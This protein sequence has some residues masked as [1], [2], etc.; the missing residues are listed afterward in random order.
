MMATTQKV[1]PKRRRGMWIIIGIVGILVIVGVGLLLVANALVG[2]APAPLQLLPLSPATQSASADSLDGTWITGDSSIA[3]FRVPESFLIQSS[4]I[5]GRTSAV[6]GSLLISHQEISSAS[7]QVDLSKITVPV[8]GKPNASF[9]QILE[10]SKYPNAMLTLA[11]PIVFSAIPTNGQ[12]ISS[13][14]AAL[15]TMRGVTHPVTLTIKARSNGSVLE[16]AGS[17]SV[18]VSEW[19]IQ[20]PFA[21][22]NDALIEFLVMLHRG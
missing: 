2:P 9:F 19:G 16:A 10:T 7:F 15:L 18:F 12:I 22:Q 13:Q 21:V 4:T 17:A 1:K 6:T 14:A 11:R 20:S 8:G 3:G 5:V